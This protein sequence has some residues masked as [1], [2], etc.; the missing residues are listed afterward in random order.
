MADRRDGFVD[1]SCFGPGSF[2]ARECLLDGVR[3]P[4]VA[5]HQRHDAPG[6]SPRDPWLDDGD[7]E[8]D[9]LA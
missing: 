5:L 6:L 9:K 2:W 1:G 3:L 7:A 8:R 4:P